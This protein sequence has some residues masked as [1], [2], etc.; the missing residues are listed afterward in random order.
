[1]GHTNAAVV[2]PILLSARA[3]DNGAARNFL[4]E[5]RM[6]RSAQGSEFMASKRC[7]MQLLRP[8]SDFVEALYLF[9]LSLRSKRE[10]RHC[11]ADSRETF[12]DGLHV[13]VRVVLFVRLRLFTLLLHTVSA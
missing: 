12:V 9:N 11:R 10:S 3:I 8:S 7:N 6:Y 1:M 4:G 13:L 2:I 5:Q